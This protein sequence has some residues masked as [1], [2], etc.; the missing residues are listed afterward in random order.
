MV[1]PPSRIHSL[2]TQ[3]RRDVQADDAADDTGHH[4]ARHEVH[5]A[6]APLGSGHASAG[7]VVLDPAIHGGVIEAR[8][9]F[10]GKC[11]ADPRHPVH[12]RSA[13]RRF[14]RNLSQFGTEHTHAAQRMSGAFRDRRLDALSQ[15]ACEARAL[16]SRRNHDLQR[17]TPDHRA[18]VKVT[19]RRYIGDIDGNPARAAPLAN[20]TA[21]FRIVD[22]R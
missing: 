22:R 12:A 16:S 8:Q 21:L 19:L 10:E 2:L 9:L 17:P 13:E 3:A 11:I 7:P 20:L 4:I 14:G 6:A 1:G 18:K 5:R 15:L